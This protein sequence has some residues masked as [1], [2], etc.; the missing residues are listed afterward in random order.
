MSCCEVRGMLDLVEVATFLPHLRSRCA[1]CV[2]TDHIP[3]I[4]KTWE[5]WSSQLGSSPP[6]RIPTTSASSPPSP[7]ITVPSYPPTPN[8]TAASPP[9]PTTSP[10]PRIP[11]S[12]HF[13][14][15]LV[16]S[17]AWKYL[18]SFISVWA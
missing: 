5:K 1:D 13:S 9:G 2:R 10:T 3:N 4:G 6:S 17:M 11:P 8:R 16:A 12:I 7:L 14:L 18:E 15:R